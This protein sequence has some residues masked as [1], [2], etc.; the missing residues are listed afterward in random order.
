V[1]ETL[2]SLLDVVTALIEALERAGLPYALGGAIAYSAW[3][4]PRATRDVD[5]NLWVDLHELELAFAVL[6]HAGVVVDRQAATQSARE[7]G[8]FVAHHGVYRVDV[9]IPS[10]PFYDEVLL[11]RQRVRLAGRDTW[12]L[13]PECLAVF[14]MLFYRPKD[15]ADV[16]RM[17]DIIGP[18]FDRAFVRSVLAGM[19]GE[20]DERVA[21][22][23]QLVAERVS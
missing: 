16:G 18:S 6:Q 23:D 9:F 11:R 3:A 15:V 7:R 2:G 8:M 14:K 21:T 12:V 5:L 22:W 17:L 1:R 4:E 20:A 13:S 10:V 19:L